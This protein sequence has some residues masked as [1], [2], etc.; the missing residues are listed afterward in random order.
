MHHK[1]AIT[2]PLLYFMVR[3]RIFTLQ[4]PGKPRKTCLALP[5]VR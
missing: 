1:T 2:S 4:T 3:T 5:Q